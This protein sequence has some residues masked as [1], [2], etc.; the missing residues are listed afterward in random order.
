MRTN[1]MG[2]RTF[3]QIGHQL[4]DD[5]LHGPIEADVL[6]RMRLVD[7][8]FAC[9]TGAVLLQMLDKAAFADCEQM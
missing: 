9:R 4:V 8:A 6:Q 3:L 7:D 5:V 2:A 1:Q